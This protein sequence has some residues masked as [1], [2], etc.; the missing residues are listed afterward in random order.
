MCNNNHKGLIMK[1]RWPHI[2]TNNHKG[3][4][5]WIA[6]A[7]N[8]YNIYLYLSLYIYLYLSIYKGH[9]TMTWNIEFTP[10]TVFIYLTSL[11]FPLVL[12]QC[13]FCFHINPQ[14]ENHRHIHRHNYDNRKLLDLITN[15]CNVVS[16]Q[17]Q[18]VQ[19]CHSPPLW[20]TLTVSNKQLSF[21][22]HV[23]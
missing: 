3:C 17:K 12:W 1:V 20:C 10:A 4:A 14:L 2:I 19:L 9:N 23:N 5:Q 15:H 22:Q 6:H 18:L 21:T 7:Q 8:S 16:I 11:L 13:S